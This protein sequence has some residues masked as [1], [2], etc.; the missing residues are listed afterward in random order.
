MTVMAIIRL[1]AQPGQRDKLCT[2]LRKSLD[3]AATPDDCL[4][5]EILLSATEADELVLLE[6]WRSVES[7]EAFLVKIR[8]SGAMD[9]LMSMM[10]NP[11]ATIH[12]QAID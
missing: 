5:I 4:G 7:H 11:P 3:P 2:V 12:Y 8:A 10:A 1:T 6:R 9:G